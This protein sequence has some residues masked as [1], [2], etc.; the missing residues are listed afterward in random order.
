MSIFHI[1]K[2]KTA[3]E[4]WVV[5]REIITGKTNPYHDGL[6]D[7]CLSFT[8]ADD[9]EKVTFDYFFSHLAKMQSKQIVDLVTAAQATAKENYHRELLFEKVRAENAP[10]LPSRLKC[11]YASESFAGI[12]GWLKFVQDNSRCHPFERTGY[13]IVE[14]RPSANTKIFKTQDGALWGVENLSEAE[15]IER[16]KSYWSASCVGMEE[17]LLEGQYV[18]VNVF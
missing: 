10:D 15:L 9:G 2:F 16:A 11:L 7:N 13:E 14:L 3:K 6:K 1:H 5:G 12:N 4:K 17:L 8:N 18:V